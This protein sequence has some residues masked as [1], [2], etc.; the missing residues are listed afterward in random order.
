MVRAER[1]THRTQ[2]QLDEAPL[3]SVKPH[4][5]RAVSLTG[6][7]AALTYTPAAAAYTLTAD[8]GSY[9]LTGRAAGLIATR[10]LVAMQRR[11]DQ[12]DEQ[13]ARDIQSGSRADLT[14]VCK[15]VALVG[16]ALKIASEVAIETVETANLALG[17]PTEV[18]RLTGQGQPAVTP[19]EQ[20]GS[21]NP[22]ALGAILAAF[23]SRPVKGKPAEDEEE[24]DGG[25]GEDDV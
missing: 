21:D 13:I 6:I 18:V 1:L 7:A 23:A 9:T 25:T 16:R 15:Q 14:E 17:G 3:C 11:I 10:V 20:P 12:L 4:P 5:F 22:A 24:L 8:A 2:T 19:A